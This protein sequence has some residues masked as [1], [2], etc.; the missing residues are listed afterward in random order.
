MSAKRPDSPSWT[1]AKK[2]G[3]EAE[4]AVAELFKARDCDV[5]KTLGPDGYDLLVQTRLEIKH[6]LQAQKTGNVA[7]EVRYK[8]KPSGIMRTRAD[9]WVFVVGG[10]AY[11]VRTGQLRALVESGNFPELPAGD[12]NLA[13]VR[14]VQ[15]DTLR[16]LPFVQ[17][18][19]LAGRGE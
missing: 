7:V 13:R 11:M 16:N 18:F 15:L 2:R 9:R 10:T 17:T 14:L 19:N 12:G 5:T 8:D 4:L 3:D 6:D 1:A